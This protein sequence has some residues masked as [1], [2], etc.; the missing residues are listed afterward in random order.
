M[1]KLKPLPDFKNRQE[2]ADYWDGN[3]ITNHLDQLTPVKVRSK[4]VPIP[5][6]LMPDFVEWGKLTA[7][8]F[9]KL[10]LRPPKNVLEDQYGFWYLSNHELLRPKVIEAIKLIT[11]AN[12]TPQQYDKLIDYLNRPTPPSG[13]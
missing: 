10:G 11:D 12:L 3:G 1:S 9:G 2:M 5:E 4:T 8:V 7:N 6:E 13:E